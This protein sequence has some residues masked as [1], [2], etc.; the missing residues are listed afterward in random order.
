MRQRKTSLVHSQRA[1]LSRID[2]PGISLF[3]CVVFVVIFAKSASS[4]LSRV[5]NSSARCFPLESYSRTRCV[6]LTS[7]DACVL[8]ITTLIDKYPT[9]IR[10]DVTISGSIFSGDGLFYTHSTLPGALAEDNYMDYIVDATFAT[11]TVVPA[12][13]AAVVL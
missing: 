1:T 12:V 3:L 2:D 10:I 11:Y 5:T 13:R 4:S 6:W 9:Q 8:T 7:T